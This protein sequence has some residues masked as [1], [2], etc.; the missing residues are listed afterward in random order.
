MT[1]EEKIEMLTDPEVKVVSRDVIRLVRR[2]EL[3]AQT[4]NL[5]LDLAR[6]ICR[7]LLTRAA[8]G[9]SKAQLD[10]IWRG[11]PGQRDIQ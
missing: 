10:E 4:R 5:L 11:M 6:A 8:P 2:R 7:D 3:A 9:A 1:V